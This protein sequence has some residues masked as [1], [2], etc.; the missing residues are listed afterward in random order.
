MCF[1]VSLWSR[2][3][4][5]VTV[6]YEHLVIN[7]YRSYLKGISANIEVQVYNVACC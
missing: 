4:I 1:M 3:S 2:K 6:W 7:L 5:V